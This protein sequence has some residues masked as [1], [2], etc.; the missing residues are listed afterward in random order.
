M[1]ASYNTQVA[2]ANEEGAAV[3]I[4]T[5]LTNVLSRHTI[6]VYTSC[7][8]R[9]PLKNRDRHNRSHY[10]KLDCRIMDDSGACIQTFN[11]FVLLDLAVTNSEVA[12]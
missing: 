4:R 1:K 8:K 11:R 12:L 9:G 5:V 6:I 2:P 10:L 3:P 7:H